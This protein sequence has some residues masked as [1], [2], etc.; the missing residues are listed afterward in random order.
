MIKYYFADFSSFRTLTW[1]KKFAKS[2]E[3]C[4]SIQEGRI[5][6]RSREVQCESPVRFHKSINKNFVRSSSPSNQSISS[7]KTISTSTPT[8]F[9]T[10]RRLHRH[11]LASVLDFDKEAWRNCNIDD[12][13]LSH[14]KS[15]SSIIDEEDACHKDF[16]CKSELNRTFC[17]AHGVPY[18]EKRN[19]LNHTR[20]SCYKPLIREQQFDIKNLK[21]F[22]SVDDFLSMDMN[23]AQSSTDHLNDAEMMSERDENFLNQKH[24]RKGLSSKFRTMSDKTQKL[25]SKLYSNSNLKS[26]VAESSND[27]ARQQNST[28]NLHTRRSLSYG[29]LTQVK[30]FDVKKAETEDGD[31]GI[32]VNES[33]ASSMTDENSE[34]TKKVDHDELFKMPP[35]RKYVQR[36]EIRYNDE[37]INEEN[38]KNE[39][40]ICSSSLDKQQ[41]HNAS[42]T[43]LSLTSTSLIEKRQK[44]YSIDSGLNDTHAIDSTTK[45]NSVTEIVTIAEK[46]DNITKFNTLNHPRRSK[47]TTLIINHEADT[48]DTSSALNMCDDD[49][50]KLKTAQSKE[51]IDDNVNDKHSTPIRK[52]PSTNFCTLPRK[53]KTS[54]HCTFHT[55][56]FEKG[57]GKKSLGFTIVGGADSPRGALG[58]FIKSILPKGQAIENGLLKA[59]DEVL[60]VNGHVCHDL[61]HQD[62]IKLFKSVKSGEIV[63]NICRRKGSVAVT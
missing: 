61:T 53:S 63:L 50:L 49:K 55:V 29:T 31:S 21:N 5:V 19:P 34:T 11:K 51:K 1:S 48:F 60:A 13:N 52:T 46:S 18:R 39:P 43:D 15:I 22:K 54:P 17:G 9:T 44:N 42:C 58:I 38:N 23:N 7:V 45:R 27:L 47:G 28:R 40:K 25:F 30:E 12:D 36:I 6:D 10:L 32:L 37:N 4:Y 14:H 3:N 8:Y 2:T 16:Y 35:E 20:L 26:T 62:A 57:P 59:G 56:I 33:G 24:K 41:K